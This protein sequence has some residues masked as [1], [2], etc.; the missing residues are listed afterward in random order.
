L[1][2]RASQCGFQIPE[3]SASDSVGEP[4]PDLAVTGRSR[5]TFKR[6]GSPAAVVIQVVTYEGRIVVAD[7]DLLRHALLSGIGPAKAYGCGLMTLAPAR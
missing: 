4:V 6:R 2:D 1:T 5:V 3:S 7:A